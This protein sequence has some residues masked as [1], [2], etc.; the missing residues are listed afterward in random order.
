MSHLKKLEI[1]D[2][3]VDNTGQKICKLICHFS[4]NEYFDNETLTVKLIY[5]NDELVKS[6][7]TEIKWKKNPT[8]KKTTKNQKNKRTGQTR[9]IVKEQQ[10]RSFF[11]LFNDFVADQDEEKDDQNDEE[12]PPMDLYTAE[13]TVNEISE[14]LPYALEYYLDV[15]KE[16]DDAIEEEDEEEDDEDEEDNRHPH[17]KKA[18]KNASRKDSEH[19]KGDKKAAPQPGAKQQECK[20]Q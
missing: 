8:L 4:P 10:L 11:E 6:E 1:N 20:Q 14:S 19:Q 3:D 12:E 18:S 9:S 13:E 7:G 15:N 16:D 2:T 17:K 5:L